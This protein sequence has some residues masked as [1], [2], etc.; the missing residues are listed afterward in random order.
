MRV[1]PG[2]DGVPPVLEVAPEV[3]GGDAVLQPRDDEAL[4]ERLGGDVEEHELPVRRGQGQHARVVHAHHVQEPRLVDAHVVV[5]DVHIH[6][7]L[8]VERPETDN[9]VLAERHVFAVLVVI[10]DQTVK[11]VGFSFPSV[12]VLLNFFF[13]NY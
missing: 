5:V 1:S 4:Q 6:L 13:N 2:Q 3:H 9:A 12:C 7:V 10:P 8:H 11:D